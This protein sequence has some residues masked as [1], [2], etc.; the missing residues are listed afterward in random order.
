MYPSPCTRRLAIAAVAAL[1]IAGCA[2]MSV[3]SYRA[4]GA[5]FAPYRTFEWGPADSL[6]TGD[7]RL[8]NSPFFRNAVQSAVER[9]LAA[10][11]YEKTTR[12]PDLQLHYHANVTQQL[13]VNGAD[14]KYGYCDECTPFV[15]DAGTLTIDLVD[16]RTNKL[17]W[18]G[19]AE[20]SIDGVVDNQE[21]MEEKIDQAVTR[22]MAMFPRKL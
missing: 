9:Q 7:P 22:I 18:R 13:D 20:G 5:D 21:W 12:M 10:R 17:V 6:A 14:R 15:Y 2:T 11:G 3:R 1:T 19:W 4:G 8:D 16:M